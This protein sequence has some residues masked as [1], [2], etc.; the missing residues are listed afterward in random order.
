MTSSPVTTGVAPTPIEL[1]L[2]TDNLIF[3]HLLPYL[4]RE[5]IKSVSLVSKKIS[6]EVRCPLYW[7]DLVK[8]QFFLLYGSP[9]KPTKEPT[10]WKTL[11]QQLK[12]QRTQERIA[13]AERALT[14]RPPRSYYDGFICDGFDN[15][16]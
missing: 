16:F 10:D 1:L 8:R 11:Y 7:K 9:V 4:P 15:W 2:T 3:N 12:R 13:R 5:D 14:S 6:S